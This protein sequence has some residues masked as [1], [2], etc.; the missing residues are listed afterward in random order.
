MGLPEVYETTKNVNM[1]SVVASV[2]GLVTVKRCVLSAA[3][4]GL[5]VA[6]D[7]V[8]TETAAP[9]AVRPLR[10]ISTVEFADDPLTIF[11]YDEAVHVCPLVAT[12]CVLLS[13]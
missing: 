1:R 2:S 9:A 12:T 4:V 10:R 11:T 6:E 8:S 5:N 13:N 3:V 7:V